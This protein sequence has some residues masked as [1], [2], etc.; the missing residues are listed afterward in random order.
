MFETIAYLR[1]LKGMLK[2]DLYGKIR[3]LC[4]KMFFAKE[5]KAKKLFAR[6]RASNSLAEFIAR[7]YSSSEAKKDFGYLK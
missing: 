5:F 3:T 7:E 6:N 2:T 1:Q 4:N